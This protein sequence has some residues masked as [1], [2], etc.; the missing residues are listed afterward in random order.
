MKP[1]AL[2]QVFS[3]YEFL[4]DSMKVTKISVNRSGALHD[5]TIFFGQREEEYFM[6][7]RSEYRII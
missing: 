4:K 7:T 6:F 2:Q 3:T 1:D 5:N